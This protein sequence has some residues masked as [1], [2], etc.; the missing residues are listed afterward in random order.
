MNAALVAAG[1]AAT[2]SGIVNAV[3]KGELVVDEIFHVP[4][5]QRY[6]AGDWQAWD[7]K[8]TT[9]PGVYVLSAA[10]SRIIA[11]AIRS[12]DIRA[13]CTSDFLRITT[14]VPCAALAA[15]AIANAQ[16][17]TRDTSSSSPTSSSSTSTSKSS[18]S[19]SARAV[20]LS[21]FPPHVFLCG[22]YYTETPS[23]AF[24]LS[25]YAA[26]R[27]G[28]TILSACALGAAVITR[29]TN[30]VWCLFIWVR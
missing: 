16:S 11:A 24:V 23:T 29:Q 30:A 21:L 8:I 3:T 6:C 26:A 9:P 18:A 12:D 1:T 17:R 20:V 19:A 28:R 27:N 4:Q 15:F 10:T 2:T 5:A 13:L 7:A 14:N 22:L 25:A